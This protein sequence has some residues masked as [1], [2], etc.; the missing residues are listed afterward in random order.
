MSL[1]AQQISK[2]IQDAF[3]LHVEPSLR[4]VSRFWREF[5]YDAWYKARQ[6]ELEEVFK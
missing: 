3:V 1:T 5:D 2:L 4:S 6:R